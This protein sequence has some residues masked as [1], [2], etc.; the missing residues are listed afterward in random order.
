MICLFYNIT[1][2]Q[3]SFNA[4]KAEDVHSLPFCQE[5]RFS[6][7]I[8]RCL[9][10]I[11]FVTLRFQS[12]ISLSRPQTDIMTKNWFPAALQN[13][14]RDRCL[15]LKRAFGL[16]KFPIWFPPTV[17]PWTSDQLQ[18]AHSH[19]LPS[20]SGTLQKYNSLWNISMFSSSGFPQRRW[21]LTQTSGQFSA[22]LQIK[23]PQE[24]SQQIYSFRFC[25]LHN[26]Q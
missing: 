12:L 14:K 23:P 26:I 5:Q 22:A 24:P 9:G 2:Y 7:G 18:D 15:F 6:S 13:I 1:G 11:F 16:S 8:E 25:K 3:I 20:Q 17:S 10:L 19:C 21:S 4:P